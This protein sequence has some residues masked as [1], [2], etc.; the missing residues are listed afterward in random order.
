MCGYA[1]VAIQT[2]TS[3]VTEYPSSYDERQEKLYGIHWATLHG[4]CMHTGRVTFPDGLASI[5]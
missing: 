4:L 2:S 5:D 1:T 3:G